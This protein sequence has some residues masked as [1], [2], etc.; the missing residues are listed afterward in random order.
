M[1]YF[2]AL[3]IADV[4]FAGKI[5]GKKLK[6]TNSTFFYENNRHVVA[7]TKESPRFLVQIIIFELN[8]LLCS[9]IYVAIATHMLYCIRYSLSEFDSAFSV[10][11]QILKSA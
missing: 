3:E 10:L 4:I 8:L 11:V 9:D 7:I 1:F 6:K 5:T 2:L